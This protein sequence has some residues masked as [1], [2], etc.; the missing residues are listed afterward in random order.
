MPTLISK[1]RPSILKLHIVPDIEA[2]PLTFNIEGLVFDIVHISKSGI[3]FDIEAW[4]M[5][6]RPGS[7]AASRTVSIS[8]SRYHYSSR[9]AGGPAAGQ[10]PGRSAS[11]YQGIIIRHYSF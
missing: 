7:R 10:P 1:Y 9:C 11:A 3:C 6:R 8:I 4:Q 2:K 5:R